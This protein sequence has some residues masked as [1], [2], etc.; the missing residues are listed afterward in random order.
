MRI[1][2]FLIIWFL[3]VKCIYLILQLIN[4]RPMSV[5][6]VNFDIRLNLKTKKIKLILVNEKIQI[7]ITDIRKH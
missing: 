5:I 2:Y 4:K 7:K 6:L 1:N 3:F